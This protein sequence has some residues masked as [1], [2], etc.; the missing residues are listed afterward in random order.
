MT[1]FACRSRHGLLSNLVMLAL[2]TSGLRLLTAGFVFGVST[3]LQRHTQLALHRPV[4]TRILMNSIMEPPTKHAPPDSGKV[5]SKSDS[6]W[7]ECIVEE[8]DEEMCTNLETWVLK[9]ENLEYFYKFLQLRGF[10]PAAPPEHLKDPEKSAAYR[11]IQMISDAGTIAT[12]RQRR[13]DTDLVCTECARIITGGPYGARGITLAAHPPQPEV[14]DCLALSHDLPETP[15][16]LWGSQ[17]DS[18]GNWDASPPREIA[19][20]NTVRAV[21]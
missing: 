11:Q 5:A 8:C 6:P 2:S 13:M 9:R 4:Q 21:F 15:N 10:V 19:F 1:P 20:C 18:T 7:A 17:P 16:S 3:T 12:C 14:T